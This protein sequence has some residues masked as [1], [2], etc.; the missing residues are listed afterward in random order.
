MQTTNK[1]HISFSM[2][3]TLLALLGMS[4]MFAACN[5]D[6]KSDTVVLNSF[7]PSPIPLGGQVTFIGQNLDK[8]TS[9]E[10]PGYT[11]ESSDFVSQSSDKIEVTATR[12][13]S[14]AIVGIVRLNTSKGV[15]ESITKIGYR[16]TCILDAFQPASAK[17]GQEITIQGEYLSSV[18]IVKFSDGVEIKREQFISA[19]NAN[20]VVALPAEAQ[21]GKIAISDGIAD[22]YSKDALDVVLPKGTIPETVF[23]NG[24]DDIT[25]TGTDLDLVEKVNFAGASV[26]KGDFKSATAT[27]IVLAIPATAKPEDVALEAA[28]GVNTITGKLNLVEPEITLPS[29]ITLQ[30]SFDISGTNLDL[31]ASAKLGSD[32]TIDEDTR[33]ED[34]M[35]LKS[36]EKAIGKEIV[37]TLVNGVEV[38]VPV[39]LE[40][41][42]L[43]GIDNKEIGH[44]ST[45]SGARLQDVDKV[46]IGN[47][48][49]GTA[50]DA[51]SVSVYFTVDPD[52]LHPSFPIN[53]IGQL[54]V[55]LVASN[56][57][58]A[59]KVIE[60]TECKGV[61]LSMVS[62]FAFAAAAAVVKGSGL[63]AVNKCMIDGQ[64]LAFESS[65][66][67]LF[68]SMPILAAT[69]SI[70]VE[71]PE[72]SFST[73]PVNIQIGGAIPVWTGNEDL[74]DWGRNLDGGIFPQGIFDDVKVGSKIRFYIDY[75]NPAESC[76]LQFFAGSWAGISCSS[77]SGDSHNQLSGTSDQEYI[78]MTV[79]QE[80]MD[81]LITQSTDWGG[82]FILQ[83]QNGNVTKITIVL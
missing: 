32:L 20:I 6:D 75:H 23:K 68:V 22:I 50:E 17:P 7:G 40:A 81:Q 51:D 28:S 83:G 8:V 2:L 60:F 11:V 69:K 15:V 37:F 1:K 46:Y 49:S 35:T 14:K 13:T 59:S 29:S 48:I 52:G 12:D 18:E 33:A 21:T 36:D 39:V 63:D 53:N 64:S 61:S 10:F 54:R 55:T 79:D 42:T 62:E 77:L 9:I 3:F 34:A 19:D 67:V 76:I 78:E 80:I 26:A 65:S 66:S 73:S 24:V 58:E 4:V 82:A 41:V 31:V 27:S 56:G 43:E 45:I 25:I 16:F 44:K 74:G 38:N 5:D 57:Q 70:V 71:T 47:N 30:S 72:Y